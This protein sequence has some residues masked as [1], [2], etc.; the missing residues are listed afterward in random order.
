MIIPMIVFLLLIPV[1]LWS[2]F[3]FDKLVKLEYEEFHQQWV[4]DGEPAG[5]YWRPAQSRSSSRSGNTTQ[6]IMIAWFLKAP[7]WV[8]SNTDASRLFKKYRI[9]VLVWN[10]FIVLWFFLFLWFA[11]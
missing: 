4:E 5:M 6:R 1:L 11:R 9:L 7:Q 10:F 8:E 3:T 2:F